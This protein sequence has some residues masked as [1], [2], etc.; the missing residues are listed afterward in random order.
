MNTPDILPDYHGEILDE[1]LEVILGVPT[2]NVN[3]DEEC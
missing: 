3:Y 2:K 1:I